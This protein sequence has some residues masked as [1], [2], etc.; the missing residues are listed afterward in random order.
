MLGIFNGAGDPLWTVTAA[1]DALRGGTLH[2]AATPT[3]YCVP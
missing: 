3:A 1:A 2:I